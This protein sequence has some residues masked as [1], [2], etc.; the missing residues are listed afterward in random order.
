MA[1]PGGRCPPPGPRIIRPIPP[2][3]PPP[4]RV[5]RLPAQPPPGRQRGHPRS[6]SPPPGRGPPIRGN[7]RHGREP[8][9]IGSCGRIRRTRRGRPDA[10]NA[11]SGGGAT[12]ARG[13]HCDE[14]WNTIQSRPIPGPTGPPRS[15][16]AANGSRRAGG[17]YRSILAFA[18][19]ERWVL[20]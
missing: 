15:R 14:P 16:G 9:S 12:E 2:P 19:I 3:I 1:G 4:G 8:M 13:A 11:T 18:N 7:V 17:Q 5:G 10:T 6:P 20:L